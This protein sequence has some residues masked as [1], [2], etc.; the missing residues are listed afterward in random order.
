EGRAGEEEAA[1]R[2]HGERVAPDRC[3]GPAHGLRRGGVLLPRRV[4]IAPATSP[5]SAA[6]TI[7]TSVSRSLATAASAEEGVQPRLHPLVREHRPLERAPHERLPPARA[8][9]GRECG[10]RV[11]AGR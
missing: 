6:P 10:P 11:A 7:T 8:R 1:D 3:P 4:R 2:R 5:A 9:E